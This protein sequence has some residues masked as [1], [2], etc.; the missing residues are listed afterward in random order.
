MAGLAEYAGGLY[1]QPGMQQLL[2][3]LQ[4][5]GG[6]DVLL[7]LTACWLGRWQRRADP[8]LWQA[9]HQYQAPWREQIITPLR[10]VRRTLAGDVA[11]TELYEQVKACEL[12]AEWHQLTM[13]EGLC[14]ASGSSGEGPANCILAHLAQCSGER[15]DARLRALAAA[16]AEWVPRVGGE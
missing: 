4:D 5:D 16:A 7:L 8:G 1:A 12:A 2:L 10:Q 11:V 6:H 14:A 9:I 13:L 3:E 15:I